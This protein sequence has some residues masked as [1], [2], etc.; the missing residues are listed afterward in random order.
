[1]DLMIKSYIERAEN[2]IVIAETLKRLSNEA[3]AKQF[4]GISDRM[5]F[6][7]SAISHSYYA[8]FYAAK[9]ILLTKNIKTTAPEIHKK[10]FE[11]FKRNF[12]DTGI[13]NVKLLE[14]YR[15]MVIRADELLEIFKDEKW[16]R[17]NFTYNTIPQ[18]NKEPAEDSLKKQNYLFQT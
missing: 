8:I 2:E 9:A 3:N 6:Y 16:K 17:G 4:F 18:A 13:L 12:V 1:M 14:I 10:T 11:E 5:T 15:K 7:S